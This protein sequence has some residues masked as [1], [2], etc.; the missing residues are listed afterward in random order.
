MRLGWSQRWRWSRDE[1]S[2]WD[3]GGPWGGEVSRT[4]MP[5]ETKQESNST[6]W[7]TMPQAAGKNRTSQKECPKSDFGHIFCNY[8]TGI[9]V[10]NLAAVYDL[11][12]GDLS[13]TCC[14]IV[15][16]HAWTVVHLHVWTYLVWHVILYN[17]PVSVIMLIA[18]FFHC[19]DQ[20]CMVI[21]LLHSF[22]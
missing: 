9:C 2:T 6:H 19:F 1:G 3:G 18:A 10:L 5:P 17:L 8:C 16:P 13:I 4:Q 20:Q 22:Y 7:L 11:L 21:S 14:E 12:P 15:P